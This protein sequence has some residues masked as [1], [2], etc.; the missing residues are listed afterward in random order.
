MTRALRPLLLG[1]LI[2]C[3]AFVALYAVQAL[4]CTWAWPEATHRLISSLSGS[5]LSPVLP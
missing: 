5:R 1:F 2:W 4:G 3:L